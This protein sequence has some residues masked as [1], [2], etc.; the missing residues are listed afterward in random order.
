MQ[1]L[2]LFE[3]IF[4]FLKFIGLVRVQWA[5]DQT[6]QSIDFICDNASAIGH[7]ASHNREVK[8]GFC[9]EFVI[10]GLDLSFPYYLFSSVELFHE[11]HS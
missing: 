8:V 2:E 1:N 7:H 11:L 6:F 4:P 3:D 5:C 10:E 9:L